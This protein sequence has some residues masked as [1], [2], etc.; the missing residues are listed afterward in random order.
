MSLKFIFGHRESN[1]YTNNL[2]GLL[3]KGLFDSDLQV[4][5]NSYHSLI[6]LSYNHPKTLIPHF[7]ELWGLFKTDYFVNDKLIDVVDIGGG[8]KIKNDKGLPIRKAI[9]SS[10][11]FLLENIPEKF[12]IADCLQVLIYGLNDNEDIQMLCYSCMTK[13]A[14]IAPESYISSI[15]SL[16]YYFTEKVKVIEKDYSL[17][18]DKNKNKTGLKI[19]EKKIVDLIVHI[20]RLF[21][22]L[23]KVPEIVENPNFSNLND[24]LKKFNIEK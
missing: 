21:T 6:N 16:V 4:K 10:I 12:H 5:T 11:K 13:I 19:D 14:A 23:S 8:L 2:V 20:K 7:E 22:E 17:M 1:E 24:Y 3:I 18:N 15:E 9:F